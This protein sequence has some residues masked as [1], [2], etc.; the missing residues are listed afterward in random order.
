ML[1]DIPGNIV[2]VDFIS[3]TTAII[4]PAHVLMKESCV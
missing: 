4:Y 1:V 3:E 2:V